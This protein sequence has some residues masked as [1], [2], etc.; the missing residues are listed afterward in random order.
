MKGRWFLLLSIVVLTPGIR[1]LDE[2]LGRH[3]PG[4][5]SVPL[6]AGLALVCWIGACGGVMVAC[7]RMRKP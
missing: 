1:F 7:R 2:K 4:M 6:A 3:L 5:V